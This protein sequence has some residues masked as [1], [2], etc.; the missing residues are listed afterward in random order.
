[1]VCDMY[2]TTSEGTVRTGPL[3]GAGCSVRGPDHT[4]AERC[5]LSKG[6]T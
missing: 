1:M 2:H 6:E 4:L 3:D 5:D